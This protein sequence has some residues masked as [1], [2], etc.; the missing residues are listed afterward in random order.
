MELYHALP[1]FFYLL[2]VCMGDIREAF[3]TRLFKLTWVGLTVIATFGLLWLPFLADGLQSTLQVLIRLF[4][5]SRGLFEVNLAQNI[6]LNK[7]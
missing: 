5:F 2:G 6:I 1:F 3:S 7:K 4:P